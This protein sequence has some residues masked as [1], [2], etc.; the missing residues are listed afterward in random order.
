M[1]GE[2]GRTGL[3]LGPG[4]SGLSANDVVLE[5]RFLV[6]AGSVDH[7]AR[8]SACAPKFGEGGTIENIWAEQCATRSAN[9][10]WDTRARRSPRK[11]LGLMSAISLTLLLARSWRS[12][13]GKTTRAGMSC[14]S[15]R[16]RGFFWSDAPGAGTSIWARSQGGWRVWV[17]EG[18]AESVR[19]CWRRGYQE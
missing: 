15:W 9:R 19:S 11:R 2:H 12:F 16:R 10:W 6:R 14:T 4:V 13:R 7:C 17:R 3:C 5:F 8:R 1:R 18:R